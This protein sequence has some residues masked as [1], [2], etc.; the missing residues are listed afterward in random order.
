MATRLS[1]HCSAPRGIEIE[2]CKSSCCVR[3]VTQVFGCSI[4]QE[5]K[6]HLRSERP[7]PAKDKGLSC[8]DHHGQKQRQQ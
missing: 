6:M 3:W 4:W 7:K 2:A 8:R 5:P 1:R